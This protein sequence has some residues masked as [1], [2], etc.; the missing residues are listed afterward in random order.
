LILLEKNGNIFLKREIKENSFPQK[1]SAWQK[2]KTQKRECLYASGSSLQSSVLSSQKACLFLRAVTLI[3]FTIIIIIT[4][5]FIYFITHLFSFSI[6]FFSSSPHLLHSPS[7]NQI[8]VPQ[9]S[10]SR[11][12][13]SH[14]TIVFI[15]ILLSI[16]EVH[17]LFWSVSSSLHISDFFNEIWVLRVCFVVKLWVCLGFWITWLESWKDQAWHFQGI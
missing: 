3:K 9:I 6:Y 14:L 13:N 15:P 2:Q 16:F 8:S 17:A 10:L 5:T 1:Q 11:V 4:F 12:F 7:L